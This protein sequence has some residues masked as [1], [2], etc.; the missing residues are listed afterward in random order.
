MCTRSF[1]LEKFA[2]Q[3]EIVMKKPGL[4]RG[5]RWEAVLVGMYL[6]TCWRAKSEMVS[7]LRKKS[8]NLSSD[9]FLSIR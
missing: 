7:T 3:D 1:K 6:C 2:Q 4:A 5:G 8:Q 9:L